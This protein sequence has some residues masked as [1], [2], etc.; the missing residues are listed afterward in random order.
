[1]KFS[2]LSSQFSILIFSYNIIFFSQFSFS[3]QEYSFSDFSSYSNDTSGI[4]CGFYGDGFLNSPSLNNQ[5]FH[6]FNNSGYISE[7]IK[8]EISQNLRQNNKVGA[9]LNYGIFFSRKIKRNSSDS[10]LG[11]SAPA[12]PIA[13]ERKPRWEYFIQISD[14][15][16]LDGHF[17]KDLFDLTFYGNKKFAGDTAVLDNTEINFLRYQQIQTGII[18]LS[19]N[20]NRYGFA[21]SFLKG[22]ENYYIKLNRARLF[23]EKNG[24]IIDADFNAEIYQSDTSKKGIEAFHGWG[25]SSDLF[26]EYFFKIKEHNSLFRVEAND[27][28]F[29]QWNEK[30]LVYKADTSINF[31]GIYISDIFQLNDSVLKA[32]SPDTISQDLQSAQIMGNY[33]NFLPAILKFTWSMEANKFLFS[34]GIAHRLNAN[35]SPFTYFKTAYKF[36]S[37]FSASSRISYGGYGKVSFGMELDFALKN[38]ILQIGSNNLEGLVF[39]KYSGGNSGFISLRKEF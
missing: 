14:R 37:L 23:T 12:L 33:L 22:E 3:Q 16:H 7:E 9:D 11:S 5:F 24:E 32:I 38:F 2:N 15:A 4:S 28:G 21:L 20:K 13:E 34:F 18:R 36:S 27:F 31:E 1:M 6:Q 35:Y 10:V 8:N 29:I 30:S 19:E 25:I 17:P 26:G 39:K